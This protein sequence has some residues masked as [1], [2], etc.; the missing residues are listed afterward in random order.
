MRSDRERLLDIT[1][2]TAK[3]EKYASRGRDAFESDELIQNW[4]L[5]HIQIIGEAACGVSAE[6]RAS[7]PEVEWVKIAGMRNVL[8]HDYFG[9]HTELVWDT[10]V[11]DL[12]NLKTKI[13]HIIK[14]K[15][16][17]SHRV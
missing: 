15:D 4:I 7:H 1:E 2:A 13:E 6:L 3:I 16:E 17:K 8:V 11:N 10:V 9:I 5:R 12:P 14:L